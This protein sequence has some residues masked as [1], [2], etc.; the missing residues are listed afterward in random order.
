M[1]LAISTSGIHEHELSQTNIDSKRFQ[2]IGADDDDEER[3]ICSLWIGR[4]E[5]SS[6]Q[7][8]ETFKL[9]ILP[10]SHAPPLVFQSSLWGHYWRPVRAAGCHLILVAWLIIFLHPSWAHLCGV[11]YW[12]SQAENLGLEPLFC[13][14]GNCTPAHSSTMCQTVSSCVWA[15]APRTVFRGRKL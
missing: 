7:S 10:K 6:C 9:L 14:R 3:D 1:P 13:V 4:A 8:L 11:C 2:H 12:N 5:L 15:Q